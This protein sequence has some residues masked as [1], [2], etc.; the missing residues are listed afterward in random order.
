MNIELFCRLP[1]CEENEQ[2]KDVEDSKVSDW[3][4]IS[5]LGAIKESGVSRHRAY[6]PKHSR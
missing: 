5:P 3:E 6:C 2:F 4:E 1:D